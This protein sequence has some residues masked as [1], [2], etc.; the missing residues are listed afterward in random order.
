MQVGLAWVTRNCVFIASVWV[1]SKYCALLLPEVIRRD[2]QWPSEV[3]YSE[4]GDFTVNSVFY[5]DLKGSMHS[6]VIK[7]WEP[8]QSLW[9]R[10][11]P[12]TSDPLQQCLQPGQLLEQQ[13][14]CKGLKITTGMCSWA[15]YGQW[16]TKNRKKKKKKTLNCS[17]WR[18]WRRNRVSG[19]N[20]EYMCACPLH[21]APKGVGRLSKQSL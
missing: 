21:T 15:N 2:C 7:P 4:L 3:W 18:T 19:T 12:G 9:D 6:C 13:R 10:L 20:A 5:Q 16:D 11:G 8:E 1:L 14:N 17:F